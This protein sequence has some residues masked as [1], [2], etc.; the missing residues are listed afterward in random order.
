[1]FLFKLIDYPCYLTAL[2][3]LLFLLSDYGNTSAWMLDKVQNLKA[4]NPQNRFLSML[5]KKIKLNEMKSQVS[6][7]CLTWPYPAGT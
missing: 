2:C 7:D 4:L 1:M 3:P 5:A 6:G